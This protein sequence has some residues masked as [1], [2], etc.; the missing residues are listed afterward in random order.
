MADPEI[1]M[2]AANR[3][4]GGS[5]PRGGILKYPIDLGN[6]YSDSQNFVLFTIKPGGPKNRSKSH[7]SRFIALHIPSIHTFLI[8]TTPSLFLCHPSG[9]KAQPFLDN[10][11]S[12]QA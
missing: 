10:E 3:V 6:T 8:V 4:R 12:R 5:G 7:I 9:R 1:Q 11:F 2:A